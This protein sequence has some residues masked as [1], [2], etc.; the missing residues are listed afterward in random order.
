MRR[1][2]YF[3]GKK[4]L[5]PSS[6]KHHPFWV[7][8]DAV[9]KKASSL[10]LF[11]SPPG[12]PPRGRGRPEPAQ[13]GGRAAAPPRRGQHRGGLRI[14]A[15]DPRHAPT[16]ALDLR[17][18]LL[19]PRRRRGGGRTTMAGCLARSQ[20]RDEGCAL[21]HRRHV[22]RRRRMR[23]AGAERSRRPWLPC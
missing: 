9:G 15:L 2:Q 3:N 20:A 7:G 4:E 22:R 17:L 10:R 11:G 14:A 12:P 18:L 5:Q 23:A 6:Q 19:G 8:R 21:Q 13:H 1:A 16:A